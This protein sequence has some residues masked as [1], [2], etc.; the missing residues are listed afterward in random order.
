MEVRLGRKWC[1]KGRDLD[2]NAIVIKRF[3]AL[4]H[5]LDV[6][7]IVVAPFKSKFDV[8]SAVEIALVPRSTSSN[9]EKPRRIREIALRS[10]RLGSCNAIGA[11]EVRGFDSRLGAKG[12]HFFVVS[13][14]NIDRK[15]VV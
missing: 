15:S 9:F 4:F 1:V 6:R 8:M 13:G 14:A 12:K 7:V 2:R 3:D 5:G 11:V 10:S